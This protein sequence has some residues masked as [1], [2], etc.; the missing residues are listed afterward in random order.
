MNRR[1]F[2]K[3]MLRA[4]HIKTK[5]AVL[6]LLIDFYVVTIIFIFVDLS[7]MIRRQWL[8]C[9]FTIRIFACVCVESRQRYA[10][11]T[12]ASPDVDAVSIEHYSFYFRFPCLFIV[13]AV[14]AQ[15]LYLHTYRYSFGFFLR[16]SFYML[17][18]VGFGNIF[19]SWNNVSSLVNILPCIRS[20][21][22]SLPW[23]MHT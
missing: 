4:R 22:F 6:L 1:T 17:L 5:Y 14:V 18:N 20:F 19:M 8:V 23:R 12:T 11:L 7:I 2:D 21:L 3:D 15:V 10:W 9:F 13:D 16:Y